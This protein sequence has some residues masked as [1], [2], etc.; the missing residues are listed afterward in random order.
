MA[1]GGVRLANLNEGEGE[2]HRPKKNQERAHQSSTADHHAVGTEIT[3][4]LYHAQAMR[5]IRAP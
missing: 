4:D 2:R 3:T 5:S 1:Q